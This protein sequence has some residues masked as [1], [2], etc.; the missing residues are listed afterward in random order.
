MS[1]KDSAL[2]TGLL[3][4][5]AQKLTEEAEDRGSQTDLAA[6]L[7]MLRSHLIKIIKSKKADFATVVEL[8]ERLGIVLEYDGFIVGPISQSGSKQG[9]RNKIQ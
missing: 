1:F 3:N 5:L 9:R 7:G 2:A 4:D 8:A 6:E